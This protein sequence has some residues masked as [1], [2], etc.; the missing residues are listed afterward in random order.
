[1][2]SVICGPSARVSATPCAPSPARSRSPGR[3]PDDPQVGPV[4]LSG[5]LREV[6]G[7]EALVVLVHG[8]GGSVDSH[9]MPRGAAAVEAAGLSCLRLNLR[10]ADRPER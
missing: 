6:A 4:R 1:M 5:L 10:G 3:P 2:L 8:L 9:Y 7:A